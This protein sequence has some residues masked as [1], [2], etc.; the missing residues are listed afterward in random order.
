MKAEGFL[1]EAA[2]EGGQYDVERGAVGVGA[3]RSGAARKCP[4]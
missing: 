4:P 3:H 2:G 1:G